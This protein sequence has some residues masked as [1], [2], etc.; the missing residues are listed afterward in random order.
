MK[1]FTYTLVTLIAAALAV[2]AAPVDSSAGLQQREQ[3]LDSSTDVS[4]TQAAWGASIP[5]P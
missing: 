2:G 5:G 4:N 3:V 1:S